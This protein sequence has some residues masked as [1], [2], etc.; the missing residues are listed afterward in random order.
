[1]SSQPR[2]TQGEFQAPPQRAPEVWVADPSGCL[3]LSA[4]TGTPETAKPSVTRWDGRSPST[5]GSSR[6]VPPIVR[7]NGP[8]SAVGRCPRT[9]A[10]YGAPYVPFCAPAP[11]TSV[12]VLARRSAVLRRPP[13]RRRDIGCR[14]QEHDLRPPVGGSP[15][16]TG[17]ASR[18]S[19]V[20]P[21]YITTDSARAFT[22]P[23]T[24][25]CSSS[26]TVSSAPGR[27]SSWRIVR[28]VPSSSPSRM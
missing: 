11:A 10:R 19:L 12:V 22:A 5:V 4:V 24:G 23:S 28:V 16:D 1:M 2:E 18:E 21:L 15:P 9:P 13:G 17:Q 20:P 7:P 3:A 8:A 25:L 27:G 26:S 6:G 14:W